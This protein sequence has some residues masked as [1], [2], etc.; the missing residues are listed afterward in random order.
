[1]I[2]TLLTGALTATLMLSPEPSAAQTARPAQMQNLTCNNS[3]KICELTQDA[4]SY[5]DAD[6]N[7]ICDNLG[8]QAGGGPGNGGAGGGY[9]IDADGD[10]VCDNF[11]TQAGGGSGN[12][13]AG[14][15]YFTDADGDGVCDN[16]G[17]QG[18]GSGHGYGGNHGNGG[19]GGNGYR[20]GRGR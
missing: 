11:G 15:G 6:G 13:G 5:I 16:F 7:G 2:K 8:T 19:N 18:G 20:G 4:C 17:T 14:G 1:M 12:G 10:G 3:S 9:F